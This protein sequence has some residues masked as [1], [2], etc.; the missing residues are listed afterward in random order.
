MKITFRYLL[1]I[2]GIYQVYTASRNIHGIYHEYTWYILSD[3][4][5]WLLPVSAISCCPEMPCC[6]HVFTVHPTLIAALKPVKTERSLHLVYV[7]H[8]PCIYLVYVMYIQGIFDMKFW[9]R[10]TLPNHFLLQLW[11]ILNDCFGQLLAYSNDLPI[12]PW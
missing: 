1:Y 9:R 6:V 10:I 3:S 11:I 2:P 5:S 8:I 7:W 4:K 12:N